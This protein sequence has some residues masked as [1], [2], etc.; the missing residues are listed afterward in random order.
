MRR[1]DCLLKSK[2]NW[3]RDIVDTFCPLKH[4]W[5]A[6][7]LYLCCIYGVF[8]FLD[9]FFKDAAARLSSQPIKLSAA[10]R[11][12]EE[13]MW[14]AITEAHCNTR[15]W[16]CIPPTNNLYILLQPLFQFVYPMQNHYCKSVFVLPECSYTSVCASYCSYTY[17]QE[18]SG[19]GVTAP[20]SSV[21]SQDYVAN[22]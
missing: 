21:F 10:F 19:F 12:W 6:F 17:F 2:F 15:C 18:V 16:S 22:H 9:N 7:Y 14:L 13:L 5:S 3:K 8:V 11:R 20:V 4:I 1:P